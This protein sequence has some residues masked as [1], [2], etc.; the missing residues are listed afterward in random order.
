MVD[1]EVEANIQLIL[2]SIGG[3]GKPILSQTDTHLHPT[4]SV[5]RAS[6][7]VLTRY[8]RMWSDDRTRPFTS[9]VCRRR[10]TAAQSAVPEIASHAA[11]G[12]TP[13]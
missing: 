12:G 9:V 2:T 13:T 6:G 10:R 3:P 8:T 4:R 7:L 1:G 11:D 5:R